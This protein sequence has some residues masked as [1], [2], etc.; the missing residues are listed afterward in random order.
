LEYDLARLGPADPA[1]AHG[2]SRGSQW[3]PFSG[4]AAGGGPAAGG[5][6]VCSGPVGTPDGNGEWLLSVRA[7]SAGPLAHGASSG[8]ELGR[9]RVQFCVQ[10][11]ALEER[12][13]CPDRKALEEAVAAAGAPGG[14]RGRVLPSDPAQVKGLLDELGPLLEPDRT[15]IV[16]RAPVVS[17]P[18]LL[19]LLL[20]ALAVDV[21]LRR[22]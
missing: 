14:R 11:S 22:E 12:S 9:D 13:A 4:A 15:T 10:G 6:Q 1:L 8:T 5:P 17:V 21:W 7:S 3:T 20:L 2:V 19:A 18:G 16:T